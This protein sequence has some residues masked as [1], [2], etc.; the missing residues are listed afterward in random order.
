MSC[1]QTF[2]QARN[3][4]RSINTKYYDNCDVCCTDLITRAINNDSNDNATRK[5]SKST[6]VICLGANFH[7]VLHYETVTRGDD[8]CAQTR[9]TGHT[10]NIRPPSKSRKWQ[11]AH[12][13]TLS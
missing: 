10:E 4:C 1:T 7:K 6:D 11:C 9:I 13:G 2:R 12:P 8:P 5:N 3:G